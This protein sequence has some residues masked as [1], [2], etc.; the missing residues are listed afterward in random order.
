VVISLKCALN[1]INRALTLVYLRDLTSSK[2]FSRGSPVHPLIPFLG[3]HPQ[4]GKEN[5]NG[6]SNSGNGKGKFIIDARD[7]VLPSELTQSFF[8][9]LRLGGFA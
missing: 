1:K 9:S 5:C 6:R 4:M 8:F 2:Y 3:N 7:L